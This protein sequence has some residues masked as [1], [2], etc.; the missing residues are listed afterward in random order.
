M[1]KG[2]TPSLRGVLWQARGPWLTLKEPARLL[3]DSAGHVQPDP[4]G[5]EIVIHRA[6][7]D[8]IQVLP[9]PS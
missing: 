4:L 6:N 9:V 1:L 8:Y 2:N 3:E 7:V 5:G